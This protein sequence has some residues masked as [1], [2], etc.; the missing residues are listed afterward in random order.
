MTSF[1]A[2]SEFWL[3]AHGGEVYAVCTALTWA[4][5]V[6]LF[7]VLGRSIS[8]F[9]INL[10]KNVVG[11]LLLAA[12]CVVLGEPLLPEVP[13]RD[14]WLLVGSGALGIGIADTLILRAIHML[15]ASRTAIVECLYSPFV[16]FFS[17]F[18]LGEELSFWGLAGAGLV[19]GSVLLL[20]EKDR[21]AES[22]PPRIFWTGA[23]LGAASLALMA[24]GIVLVKPQLNA[25][26]VT[27]VATIR[28][29]GGVVSLL[30]LLPWQS[31]RR[32]IVQLF[33]PGAHWKLL[34]PTAILSAYVAILFWI[35]GMKYAQTNVSSIL[36]QTSA[37]WIVLFA[38]W[39]LDE[40]FNLRKA[41]ALFLALGGSALVLKG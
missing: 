16:I 22:I 21:G 34:L 23:G 41:A 2:I 14:L 27:W 17:Y 28:M 18:L 35:A 25:Y 36:N 10:F 8:A 30:L 20:I 9:G 33:A 39:F 4:V 11:L 24:Y 1:P 32:A 38:V 26:S 7:R 3:D 37:V 13:A 5:A 31:E 6:I 19:V 40:K 15:G 12:T 29:C